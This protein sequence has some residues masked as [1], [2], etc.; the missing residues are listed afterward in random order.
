MRQFNFFQPHTAF[1]TFSGSEEVN[2]FGAVRLFQ[3]PTRGWS[4][5]LDGDAADSESST[6]TDSADYYTARSP[7]TIAPNITQRSATTLGYVDSG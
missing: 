1:E 5:L 7:G 4:R 3:R 6:T 2:P